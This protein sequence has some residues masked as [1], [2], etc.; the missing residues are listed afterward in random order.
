MGLLPVASHGQCC[1]AQKNAGKDPGTSF[2][3]FR[4]NPI[5]ALDLVVAGSR[6]SGRL[7]RLVWSISEY[8]PGNRDH[9][10]TWLLQKSWQKEPLAYLHTDSQI[11]GSI[12]KAVGLGVSD[13]EGH[14]GNRGVGAYGST[15]GVG[16]P[17]LSNPYLHSKSYL[18][19]MAHIKRPLREPN[20]FL[21]MEYDRFW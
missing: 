9:S 8:G 5:R 16:F 1:S 7:C 21:W 18:T 10:C 14:W 12:P 19:Q 17:F 6:V 15:R 13:A 4:L 2:P 20:G 11:P 3:Y